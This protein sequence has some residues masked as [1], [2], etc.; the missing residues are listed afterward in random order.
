ME[1]LDV[2]GVDLPPPGSLAKGNRQMDDIE[3]HQLNIS[4]IH[5]L[6]PYKQYFLLNF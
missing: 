4:C 6:Q 3:L 5:Y 2:E 1:I